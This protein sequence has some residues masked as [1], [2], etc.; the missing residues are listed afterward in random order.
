MSK[1]FVYLVCCFTACMTLCFRETKASDI[2]TYHPRWQVLVLIYQ[3]TDYSFIDTLGYERRVIATMSPSEKARAVNAATRFFTQ[4]VP[5]LTSYNMYPLLTIRYPQR[6]LNQLEPVCGYWPSPYSTQPELDPA[7]DSVIV[8]WDST[9]T[10]ILNGG[11]Y[12]LQNC[13][14]LAQPTGAGQTYAA[15]Q[16]DSIGFNDRNI[17]KHEWGHSILFYFDAAGTAP[18]PTVD[19]HINDTNILYV[20]CGTGTSYILVDETDLNP[21]PNSIYN[22]DTGFTHDYY[23]GTT[24]TPDQPDRCLGITPSAWTAGGPVTKT[25]PASSRNE[26]PIRNLYTNGSPDLSWQRVSWAIAY[27]FQVD[28]TSPLDEPYE[29]W[30]IRSPDTLSVEVTPDLPSGIYYWRVRA[31]RGDGSWGNWTTVESF[32][33]ERF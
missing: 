8:I 19:N 26:A 6:K 15:F 14:G 7:F 33:I 29:M 10:D 30:D 27:E 21:I 32:I 1:S 17:F 22:N 2:T 20:H 23:S 31:Q 5:A 18:Y 11:D 16:V 24:A 12:N 4:D 28:T 3:Q 9:G 13:G 25:A